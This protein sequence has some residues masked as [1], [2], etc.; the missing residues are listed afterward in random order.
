L[1]LK[2]TQDKE[3][4]KKVRFSL[5]PDNGAPVSGSLYV[6]KAEAEKLAKDGT[7]TIE[8]KAAS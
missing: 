4:P 6:E 8:I 1:E 5:E 7:L 3:T 2:F